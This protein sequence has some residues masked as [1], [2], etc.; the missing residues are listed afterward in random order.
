MP[1][2]VSPGTTIRGSVPRIACGPRS[3]IRYGIAYGKHTTVC[4]VSTVVVPYNTS[5][6]SGTVPA[7]STICWAV[8]RIAQ[9][10][11][12]PVMLDPPPGF[13][14]RRSCWNL[15]ATYAR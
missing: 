3:A 4:W 11:S 8:R 13:G 15:I 14:R 9:S 5:L 7:G 1:G 6:V 2:P 12:S 10:G